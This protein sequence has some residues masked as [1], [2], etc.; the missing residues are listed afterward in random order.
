MAQQTELQLIISAQNKASAELSKLTKDMNG[1]S[2]QTKT[3][4]SSFG[5]LLPMVGGITAA[6]A[7]LKKGVFDS[8]VAWNEQEKVIKQTEAVLASTKHAIGMTAEEVGNLA[9]EMQNLTAFGDEEIQGVENLILTFTNINKQVFPETIKIIADMSVALGQDLK[10]SSIQVGKALQ[11]PILGVTALRKVGVNFNGT[12]QETIKKLVETGHAMEAQKLILKELTTEFGGSA[13]KELETFGGRTKWLK[14]QVGELQESMGAGIT[15]GLTDAFIS[16]SGGFDNFSSSIADAKMTVQLWSNALI[17]GFTF[18]IRS[19]WNMAQIAVKVISLPFT[20]IIQSAKNAYDSI[21]KIVSG[22]MSGLQADMTAGWG[23][24][25]ASIGGDVADMSNAWEN[26]YVSVDQTF[27][28]MG[29]SAGQLG[30]NMGALATDTGKASDEMVKKLKEAQK[31]MKDLTDTYKESVKQAKQEIKDLK[32][33]FDDNEKK[34]GGEQ[35]T[36]IAEV[37]VQKQAELADTQKE[38]DKSTTE[39][40]RIELQAKMGDIQAF[41]TKHL[42]DQ[43]TYASA[44]A[45]V[46][47]VNGLDEIEKLKETFIVEQAERKA[48]YEAKLTDLKEH[49]KEIKK[50]YKKKLKELKDE[51]KDEGLDKIDIKV[52]LSGSGSSSKSN[53]KKRAT[54][55]S[56]MAGNEYLVGEN[57]METFVPNQSGRIEKGVRASQGSGGHTFNFNFS[58][59]MVG[60]RSSLIRE[61]KSALNRDQELNRLGAR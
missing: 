15:K 51:I 42:Q 5:S 35:A 25:F 39:E 61:I 50:E 7:F 32:T 53:T 45:E 36:S 48:E 14:N 31:K 29:A 52:S 18:V 16:A 3:N 47:R 40:Q 28:G 43:Q 26:A 24:Q 10:S 1:L 59:A 23:E 49:L 30:G 41:L 19:L 60:D 33:A 2:K 46:K 27:D 9:G 12:Q 22:D 4:Q 58:G 38:L 21:K 17:N 11:D 56:V 57:G 34:A 55:G 13:A 37:I 8:V 6:Y 54:G 20:L 44:I